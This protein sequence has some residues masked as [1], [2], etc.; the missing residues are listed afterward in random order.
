[1]H[2]YPVPEKVPEGK[3][4]V[5]HNEAIM[6]EVQEQDHATL[7]PSQIQYPV[8]TCVGDTLFIPLLDPNHL[9]STTAIRISNLLEN[10]NILLCHTLLGTDC[11]TNQFWKLVKSCSEVLEA[12]CNAILCGNCATSTHGH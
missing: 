5:C 3:L 9:L 8:Q 7:P 10:T 1:M 6:T 12:S 2:S 4:Y 11:K